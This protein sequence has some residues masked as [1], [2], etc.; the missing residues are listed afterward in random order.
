MKQ[1]SL[2][3]LLLSAS[4]VI[5]S[6][7]IYRLIDSFKGDE[8]PTDQKSSSASFTYNIQKDSFILFANYPD[9]FIPKDD[10][11]GIEPGRRPDI[12]KPA[13]NNIPVNSQGQP[14]PPDIMS[15][16][17]FLGIISNPEK[18]KTIAILNIG[19]KQWLAG[20]GEHVQSFKIQKIKKDKIVILLNGITREIPI[21][22]D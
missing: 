18:R 22:N 11:S 14:G 5:W 20:V 2:R 12:S 9:P 6:I 1:K 4:A 3:Y 15:T 19:G 8:A 21:K 10:S 7:I 17:Q 16:I 13:I